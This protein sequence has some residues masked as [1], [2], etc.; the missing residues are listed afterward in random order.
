MKGLLD[1]IET[2]IKEIKL[3][4]DDEVKSLSIR[5]KEQKEVTERLYKH[6]LELAKLIKKYKQESKI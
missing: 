5:L 6:N 1:Q 2:D 4:L 3:L